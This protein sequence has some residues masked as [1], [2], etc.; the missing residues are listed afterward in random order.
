ML[1]GQPWFAHG[2]NFWP[3][4]VMGLEKGDFFT[5]WLEPEYYIPELVEQDLALLEDM[6]V[7]LVSVQYRRTDQAPALRDFLARCHD[8][9]IRAQRVS[10]VGPSYGTGC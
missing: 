10:R 2:I 8:H 3:L 4:Y 9:G 1:D 5:H 7:N 6:G